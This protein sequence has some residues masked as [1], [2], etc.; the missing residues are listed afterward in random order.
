MRFQKGNSGR[1]KGIPN[2]K[3]LSKVKEY[4][5]SQD[6]NLVAQMWSQIELMDDPVFKFKCMEVL[7]KYC[8]TPPK[9]KEE[10]EEVESQG[11]LDV[12]DTIDILQIAS[13]SD[14]E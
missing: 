1:P 2:K 13:N 6:I 7:L 5:I 14:K 9:P 10:V 11:L 3:S 4:L 8:E 12:T